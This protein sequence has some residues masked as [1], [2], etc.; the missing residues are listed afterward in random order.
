MAQKP[1]Q[2][3]M[4]EERLS[5][6]PQPSDGGPGDDTAIEHIETHDLIARGSDQ[7]GTLWH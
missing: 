1:E 7:R 3:F 6:S 5:E 2:V 4:I